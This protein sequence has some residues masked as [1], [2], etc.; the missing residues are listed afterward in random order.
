M[1]PIWLHEPPSTDLN[2]LPVVP[3]TA[4][5]SFVPAEVKYSEI[6]V[7]EDYEFNLRLNKLGYKI[8]FNKDAIIYHHQEDNFY[9]WQQN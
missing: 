6:G 5:N 7:G 8:V 3:P 1:L 4:I 2:I 9:H